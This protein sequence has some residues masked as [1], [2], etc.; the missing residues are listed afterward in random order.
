GNPLGFVDLDGMR[1]TT[2]GLGQNSGSNTANATNTLRDW[3]N[4]IT[5]RASSQTTQE[6]IENMMDTF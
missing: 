6:E 4:L 5:F 2:F 3:W 1:P